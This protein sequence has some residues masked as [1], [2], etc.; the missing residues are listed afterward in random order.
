VI[1]PNSPRGLSAALILAVLFL[2]T[3]LPPEL[4]ASAPAVEE[5][6]SGLS[7]L[8]DGSYEDAART[9]SGLIEREFVLTDFAYLWRAQAYAA[10]G[11][12]GRAR[13]DIEVISER[14]PESD[15]HREAL[16]LEISIEEGTG[17]SPE[18][19]YERYIARYPGDRDVRYRFA[20]YMK[21]NGSVERA[22]ELFKALY[23][24][25]AEF[26]REASQEIDEAGLTVEEAIKRGDNLLRQWL[27]AEAERVFRDALVSAEGERAD[28]I[29]E[30]IA[31]CEF[32]QKKYDVSAASF[33]RL[34]DRY[35]EA[36]SYLRSG[37]EEGFL[38]G[39]DELRAMK[40]PRTGLLL[41]ALAGEK[42]RSG[43][44]QEALGVLDEVYDGYPFR[45]LAL[46][47]EGWTHYLAGE[48]ARA[49][50]TFKELARRYP[51]DK[52][53]YW[54][55][56]TA[57][58]LDAHEES[59]YAEL[60]RT[61]KD[62]YALLSCIRSGEEVR[63]V[64]VSQR[65]GGGG[66]LL[67]RYSALR[68]LE[69]RDEALGELRSLSRGLRGSEQIILYSRGLMDIGEYKQSISVATRLPY[70][71]EIHGLLYPFA[72]WDVIGEAAER[73]RVN[74]LYILS[75]AREESRLDPEARSV[76]G[77]MGLMQLMPATAARMSGRIDLSVSDKSEF[78][79]VRT[80][81]LIGSY[82]LR[83]LLDRF[84]SVTLA[85]AAYN[86]G[87]SAVERWTA[88]WQYA[89]PDE[90][91]EDIPYQETRN[92][93][94]KVLSTYYQYVRASED[95]SLDDDIL[96]DLESPEPRG[97]EN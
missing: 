23:I 42:R 79:D 84:R 75:I 95:H 12:V 30:K 83:T 61:G 63:K 3:A 88:A 57:G 5:A 17:G 16:K 7:Q 49:L 69:L 44:P 47:E 36:V 33:G 43:L 70:D 67:K 24:D 60:C 14:Y 82:Y 32:R 77:A 8:R 97:R 26:S 18:D 15:A 94:K 31:L 13:E 1:C 55:A 9:F 76:A 48:F 85:T 40:D 19:L 86:A 54:I 39:L 73:F 6:R 52:Y 27:F 45:E 96:I 66:E 41:V 74:P 37:N 78:F 38:R 22:R 4:F 64:S 25:A 53:R 50:E 71:D 65:V 58:R 20:L 87:E 11:D 68:A 59:D 92:Y 72:Y 90:F 93:V 81:I 21:R 35:M 56:R 91:V 10:A 62:Y 28:E 80:N 29:Q 51:S 46:W 34:N 89:D 2:L